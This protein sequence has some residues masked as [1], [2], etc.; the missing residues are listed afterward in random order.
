MKL[1][2]ALKTSGTF[3]FPDISLHPL[4]RSPIIDFQHF[5]ALETNCSNG[6]YFW[7]APIGG[8]MKQ[9]SAEIPQRLSNP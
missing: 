8:I 5:S 9:M 4:S 3:L 1:L 6:N 7:H 2:K